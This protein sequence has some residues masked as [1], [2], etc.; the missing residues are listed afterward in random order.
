MGGGGSNKLCRTAISLSFNG[1]ID[2]S[3]LYKHVVPWPPS[4]ENKP[5]F[6]QELCSIE[7]SNFV[8]WQ[9]NSVSVVYFDCQ[10]MGQLKH[11]IKKIQFEEFSSQDAQIHAPVFGSSKKVIL[12]TIWL[13]LQRETNQPTFCKVWIGLIL[14]NNLFAW[15]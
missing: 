11:R 8:I 4:L 14:L 15:V 7:V 13:I 6:S 5:D 12:L 2:Q 3:T 10:T 9:Y 1:Q